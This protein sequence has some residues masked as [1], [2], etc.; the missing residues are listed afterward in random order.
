MVPTPGIDS[1]WQSPAAQV[2]LGILIVIGGDS[3]PFA[4]FFFVGLWSDS[5]VYVI[6]AVVAFS[7]G[8]LQWLYVYPVARKLRSTHE[9]AA[10]VMLR[11]AGV[12]TIVNVVFWLLL[13]SILRT[14]VL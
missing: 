1:K 6:L 3:V 7:I 4:L 5:T 10:R 8:F 9:I 2:L 12:V 11:T 13:R 14:P